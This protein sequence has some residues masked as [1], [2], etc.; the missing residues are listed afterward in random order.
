MAQ[1]QN[2]RNWTSSKLKVI[3][4]V[5]ESVTRAFVEA[6]ARLQGDGIRRSAE[7]GSFCFSCSCEQFLARDPLGLDLGGG[8]HPANPC[9]RAGCGHGFLRHYVY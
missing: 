7:Q 3:D 5:E 9:L 2:S 8:D 1:T 6:R 4:E